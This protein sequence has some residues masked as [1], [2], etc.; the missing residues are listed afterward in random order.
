[1]ATGTNNQQPAFTLARANE[2]LAAAGISVKL[3][4]ASAKRLKEMEPQ[5]RIINALLRASKKDKGA[6]GWVNNLLTRAGV[7][8]NGAANQ[9]P[10]PSQSRTGSAQQPRPSRQS[11]GAQ[12]SA[13]QRPQA[14]G[15]AGAQGRQGQ[16][17]SQSQAGRGQGPGRSAGA[18]QGAS[19]SSAPQ[20]NV[21]EAAPPAKTS[22]NGNMQ[23]ADRL[24]H[25]VY[26]GKAAL[27]F[28]AD[29]TKSDVPTV[30]LDAAPSA[31]P[32]QYNWADK[33]RVQLTRDE[34]PV[35]A[36]VFLGFMPGCEFKNHGADNDKGFS[37]ENQGAR[38]FVRVFAKDQG[39]R[40]VP[41]EAADAYHV[42]ALLMR[43]IRL[44]YPW[45]DGQAVALMLKS[46]AQ[47][48]AVKGER[49]ASGSQH[50]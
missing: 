8:G 46:L 6:Q 42:T 48:A 30:A 41:V 16:K 15:D 11:N 38:I 25:H 2:L 12:P 23:L 31:G 45:L 40:A 18:N 10:G 21:S 3:D 19:A 49:P 22:D 44:C 37:M 50:H 36:A 26:G 35:V 17:P 1:M 4:A 28:E 43:Q 47:R 29:T 14:R 32:R 33:I 7:T 39:V 5:E 20:G 9:A 27:C 24:S 34:L 13:Q